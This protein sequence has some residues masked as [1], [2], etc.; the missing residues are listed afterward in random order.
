V[1]GALKSD[2]REVRT[3]DRLYGVDSICLVCKA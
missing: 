2:L 3:I 1:T